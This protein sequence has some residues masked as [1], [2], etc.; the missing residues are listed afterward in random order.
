MTKKPTFR[1]NKLLAK[2]WRQLRPLIKGGRW[3]ATES[4]SPARIREIETD[5]SI[6]NSEL[7]IM[8]FNIQ[9]CLNSKT[10]S[11]YFKS[12]LSQ[13]L[14]SEPNI[15][16]ITAIADLIK[17]YDVVGLQELDAGSHRSGSINQLT[18]LAQHGDFEFRHQQLNRN[19]GR[20]GQYSNGLLSRYI[21][22][23][24]EDHRLPGLPGR[25]AIIAR[26]K[27][28][29]EVLTVCCVHLALSEK[30]QR[31]QLAFLR[32]L[33]IADKN[34]VL[35]GD[36]NAIASQLA[37]SP[38]NDLHL[39]FPEAEL[40]SYPSWKPNRNID[41]ILVSQNITI[42]NVEVITSTLSDHCPVVTT[43]SLQ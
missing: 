24:V 26:Y 14:P 2:K 12:G 31:K 10:F 21:P 23:Q 29:D 5:S 11:D 33:L 19:L 38:I 28:K 37:V 3:L 41:H 42:S 1:E 13:F 18:F 39:R 27:L 30:A 32:D 16:H 4:K 20:F 6:S 17:S 25:G 15:P 8:T 43:L 35:M 9:A 34:I 22:F 40:H 36:M 7:R